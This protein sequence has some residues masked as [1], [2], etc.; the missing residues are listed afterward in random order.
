MLGSVVLLTALCGW[1]CHN[2]ACD[3]YAAAPPMVSGQSVALMDTGWRAS[4]VRPA[5]TASSFGCL[6]GG[7]DQGGTLRGTL[8]SFIL[9]RDPD[10][11]TVRDIEAS[12][13]PAGHGR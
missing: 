8:W 12:V 10:V 2:K 4:S 7:D 11:P 3:A 6:E 9:G 1:G 5:Y 13:Y